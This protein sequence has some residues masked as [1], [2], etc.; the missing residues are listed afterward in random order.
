LW[1][2]ADPGR[3]RRVAT[4]NGTT[5]Y[6]ADGRLLVSRDAVWRLNGAARPVSVAEFGGGEPVAFS[7][8]RD[9]LASHHT[10][11]TT[12]LW[13]IA[14]DGH[15]V[16]LGSMPEG[17]GGAFLPDGRTFVGRD[18][19]KT[20]LWDVTDPAH[21]V[22]RAV[23]TGGGSGSPSA[24]GRLLTTASDAGVVLWNVANPALP[25]RVGVLSGPG[26]STDRVAYSPDSRTVAVGS[27]EEEVTLFGTSDAVRTA[28][29]PPAPGQVGNRQIGIS[30]TLTT[31]AWS[32][33]GRELSV[34]TGNASVSVWDLTVR[35]SPVR[36]RLLIR[37]T[38][39]GGR[40]VFSPDAGTLAGAAVD[41]SNHITLWPLR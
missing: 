29:L 35:G 23:L 25:E 16:R 34:V 36:T 41:G 37:R 1:S 12:T 17:G 27:R 19:S 24:D 10:P 4:F 9:L 8:G 20:V 15:P 38:E 31:M 2:I 7:P 13:R 21:P 26:D 32:P 11:T 5:L 22:R 3:P 33:D 14:A 28:V 18:E 30:D 6:S 39:G 40:V